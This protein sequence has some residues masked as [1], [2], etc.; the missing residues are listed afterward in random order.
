MIDNKNQR[1]LKKMCRIGTDDVFC[2]KRD[3]SNRWRKALGVG[4][5][6]C[7]A[8]PVGALLGYMI[9]RVAGEKPPHTGTDPRLKRYYEILEVPPS[10]SMDEI[11]QSYRSLVRRYHPDVYRPEDE[12]ERLL[13]GEKMAGINEAYREL[14]RFHDLQT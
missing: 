14:R 6:Y 3:M 10:S 12:T 9:G 4:L 5:G 13:Q 2:W 11:R 1:M 7:V 8:G